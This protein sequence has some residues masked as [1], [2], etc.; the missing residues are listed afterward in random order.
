MSV[1]GLTPNY[2]ESLLRSKTRTLHSQHRFKR[3]L[4]YRK[5]YKAQITS[6]ARLKE[7]R[8]YIPET[9]DS[10]SIGDLGSPLTLRP[11]RAL[12]ATLEHNLTSD[13]QVYTQYVCDCCLR[14]C[15]CVIF[16]HLHI[17]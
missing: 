2:A 7:G 16:I 4:N 10:I 13:L 8:D 1:P 6:R 11:N 3:T 17:L 14:V 9:S 5:L 15:A 12:Y